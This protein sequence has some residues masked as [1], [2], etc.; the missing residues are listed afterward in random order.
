MLAGRRS[1]PPIA[2]NERN[3]K[4]KSDAK[5]YKDG[6]S[7]Y[8]YHNGDIHLNEKIGYERHSYQYYEYDKDSNRAYYLEDSCCLRADCDGKL[9]RRRMPIKCFFEV[10]DKIL[11]SGQD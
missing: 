10:L 4:M 5:Y 3:D 11:Q 8:F 7:V 6:S 1:Q 9:V 2:S